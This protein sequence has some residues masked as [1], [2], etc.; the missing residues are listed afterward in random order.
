VTF[1]FTEDRLKKKMAATNFVGDFSVDLLPKGEELL[2]FLE[3]VD[4]KCQFMNT[5]SLCVAYERYILWQKKRWKIRNDDEKFK[6]LLAPLDVCYVWL[7]HMIRTPICRGDV[8]TMLNLSDSSDELDRFLSENWHCSPSLNSEEARNAEKIWNEVQVGDNRHSYYWE[9]NDDN[10]T[11]MLEKLGEGLIPVWNKRFFVVRKLKSNGG[12]GI[13]ECWRDES[14]QDLRGSFEF[15]ADGVAFDENNMAGP[16]FKVRDS[17]SN[18]S[19]SLKASSTEE[20]RRWTR[21]MRGE[22]APVVRVPLDMDACFELKLAFLL[23]DFEWLPDLRSGFAEYTSDRDGFLTR[24]LNDYVDWHSRAHRDLIDGSQGPTLDLDL[25]WHAHIIMPAVYEADSKRLFGQVIW[26]RPAADEPEAPSPPAVPKP[27]KPS[28]PP[29]RCGRRSPQAPPPAPP[30]LNAIAASPAP[31]APPPPSTASEKRL[32]DRP[33]RC[34]RLPPQSLFDAVPQSPVDVRCSRLQ[35]ESDK[36]LRK[37]SAP[38]RRCARLAPTS[39]PISSN[40]EKT[41][42]RRCKMKKPDTSFIKSM[43]TVRCKMARPDDDEDIEKETKD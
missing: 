41:V 16:I 7:G 31:P 10:L 20:A 37:P 42:R 6:A 23:E 1:V 28:H 2:S 27:M 24:S 17:S 29:I 25:F 35:F 33:R 22:Q 12:G 19:Y 4:T 43:E 40:K 21:I 9:P 34:A 30:N 15:S 8:K 39:K 5:A 26:H 36:P 32:I 14:R 13:V 18:K 11:G 38:A 3:L